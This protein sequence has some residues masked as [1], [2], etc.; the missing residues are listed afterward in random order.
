MVATD[1]NGFMP[2]GCP[3]ACDTPQDRAH[4]MWVIQCNVTEGEG[5][6]TKKRKK[7]H[8]VPY[9]KSNSLHI[10]R[11]IPISPW[12]RHYGTHPKKWGKNCCKKKIAA[13]YGPAPLH[14]KRKNS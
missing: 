11:P 4:H 10:L 3:V 5:N 6:I 13:S 8:H 1:G 9:N 2:I 12:V 14:S 7:V